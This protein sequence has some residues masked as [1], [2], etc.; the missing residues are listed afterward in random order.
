M[1]KIILAIFTIS[2]LGLLIIPVFAQ[3]TSTGPADI[4]R[5]KVQ[6]KVRQVQNTPSAFIGS[7]TD[8]A[9]DTLQIKTLDEEIE[10]AQVSDETTY[11]NDDKGV[12][13]FGD[14]AIGDFVVAMGFANGNGVLDT[15]RV[16]VT[17]P[18]K[19]IERQ[20]VQGTVSGVEKKEV[21]L[22]LS[23][24]L[25][26]ILTFPKTWD[27]PDLDEI[28]EGDQLITVGTSDEEVFEIRSVFI[29]PQETEEESP[30][31]TPSPTPS[32]EE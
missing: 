8:I 27:G 19:E 25:S 17:S 31:P 26:F 21:T 6:D 15:R 29:I 28:S 5:E 3:E 14:I 9:E 7:I 20:A 30:S 16:L 22:T 24:G 18:T 10:Q 4:I 13:K 11:A 2:L 12:I 1:K 23:D 32:E